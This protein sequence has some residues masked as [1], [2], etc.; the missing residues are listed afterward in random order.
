[1]KHALLAACFGL[2]FA[3][4]ALAVPPLMDP[5]STEHH[6]GKDIFVQLVTPD[7]AAAKAFYG[8]LLGWQFQDVPGT[9]NPY[10]VAYLDHQMQGG[11]VQ[12]EPSADHKSQPAWLGFFSVQDVAATVAAATGRGARVLRAPH[13]VPG[14]GTEAVL[15]D[16]QGSVFGV[17]ASASG[18]PPDTLKPI[19][20][21]IWR[22]LVTSDPASDSAFYQAVLGLV[23]VKLEEP[24]SEPHVLLASEDYARASL[25]GFPANRP[26]AH[27]HWLNYVRVADATAAVAR[28]T[29]LGGHVLVPPR[30]D[31]HG[32]MIAVVA[33]PQGAPFGLLEWSDENTKAVA[34]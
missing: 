19:G 15:A 20:A 12:L 1:M 28:A 10:A 17:M 33:D 7:L 2:A 4:P 27:P 22:S 3:G 24:T 34:Q 13:S 14:L 26:Q 32:G 21:W 25:N 11:I 18:D 8:G 5:P 9:R 31:R 23:S 16:P 29:A 30:P 6:P